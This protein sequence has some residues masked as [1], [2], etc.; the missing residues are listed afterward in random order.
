MNRAERKRP[1]REREPGVLAGAASARVRAAA[2]LAAG[3]I[4]VAEA[5]YAR[6]L[7]ADPADLASL[8]DLGVVAA[9]RGRHADAIARFEAVLARQAGHADASTNL[10]LSLCDAGRPDEAVAAARRAVALRPRDPGAH[11]V[12]GHVLATTEDLAGA[13]A[14]CGSALALDPGFVPAHLRRARILRRMGNVAESLA[15]CDAV[16]RLRP[17]EVT[18]LVERGITLVEAGRQAEAEAAFREALA[19]DPSSGD[20][21]MGLGRALFETAGA[22][23]ALARLDRG[24]LGVPETGRLH[25]LRGLLLQKR[26]RLAEAQASFKRAIELDPGDASGY[27]NLGNL[28]LKSERYVES[29][30]FLEHAARLDPRTVEAYERLAEAHRQLGHHSA[31]ITLLDH[32]CGLAPERTDLRWMA[33]WARMHACA[34]QNYG[35]LIGDLMARAIAAGHT[36]SPFMI[37]AFGLPDLETHRWTRAWA[38]LTMPRRAAP[39]AHPAGTRMRAEG[40]IRLGYLS[41]DFRSHATAALLSEVLRLQDRS[42]FEL[43]G[44]NIG[45]GDGSALGHAIVSSLDRFVDLACLDD[46]EAAERIAADAVDIL[47]DLKG[48]TTDSRP[49]ILA[50]RPA[51][52]QVNYLGYPGSMGTALIDY[53][54][55]DPVVA[56]FAHQPFF[57][58]AIVHLPHSYQ[59]NDRRRA[60]P[61]GTATRA[62]HGLPPDGFVFCCF[63]NNYKLTPLVFG[64]WMR[65]LDA[66]PGSVLWLLQ[67]ND[68]AVVNLRS[69]AEQRGIAAERIVFA[70]RTG[71][72]EH[73]S[74]LGLADLFLDTLPVNAHTTASEALWAGVPVLTCR[75]SHFTSRVAAS[76]LTAVGLP[77]LITA[78]LAD[79]EREALAL[80]RDPARLGALRGRLAANR[81]TAPLF[82]TPRYVRNYEAALERMVERAEAGLLPAPFAVADGAGSGGRHGPEG[83]SVT[84]PDH[85]GFST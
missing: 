85:P 53:I 79:Y 27:L 66:V 62:A 47:V 56:P 44:Y 26:G 84:S 63:N 38:E 43:V 49:G 10:A 48:F 9:R 46:R 40:R 35:E 71:Y 74:R 18:G 4:E 19:R 60:R 14:A 6:C 2:A 58:E 23:A 42:R 15:D 76:L 81:L 5:L 82:D 55:A 73:L 77:E 83:R 52:V 41:A 33:C 69:V 17:G 75:G 36:I 34:W 61:D 13:A 1:S 80:A 64:L 22:D 30:L 37:M 21:L 54:L 72:D 31:V 78:S 70:P 28:L 45:R 50:H 11:T 25:V 68:L 59:P 39:V 24:L 57:D 67:G 29:V 3:R 51:P 65:L 7:A 20:A 8:H 32:A 16:G 12:L